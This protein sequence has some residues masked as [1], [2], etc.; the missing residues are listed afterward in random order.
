M[1]IRR[2]HKKPFFLLIPIIVVV[3]I[4]ILLVLLK[5]GTLSQVKKGDNTSAI[6]VILT[7]TGFIPSEITVK[8]GERI[9]WINKSGK[10][11]TINSDNHPTHLLYPFL[12]L[13]EFNTGSSVQ[14]V[15]NSIGTFTY[16]NHYQPSE[17]GTITVK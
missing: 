7:S 3:S 12:N 16:H 10:T 5:T 6:T 11:A 17:K 13:G 2:G 4:V 15:F 14:A 9:I 1:R 8:K